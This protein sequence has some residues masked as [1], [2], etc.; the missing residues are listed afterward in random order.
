[1]RFSHGLKQEKMNQTAICLYPEFVSDIQKTINIGKKA[2][3][4]RV[5]VPIINQ[6]LGQI[7]NDTQQNTF[8]RSDLL[9]D[10]AS[11]R[12]N[13]I[14]KV[15]EFNDC[16][17]CDET[18]MKRSIQNLKLEIDWAKH[19]NS[20]NAIVLMSLKNDECANLARQFLSK[21][22][23]Y[24]LVLAEMPMVDKS[25]F[26]QKYTS[27]GEKINLS[28]AST[29]IWHRWNCFRFTLDFN[30]QFKVMFDWFRFIVLSMTHLIISII[31]F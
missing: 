16:D 7:Q 23:K 8:T 3:Y 2:T 5:V 18:I 6:P 24:G 31:Q 15:S 25:Y 17:S 27:T 19:Q 22:D 9:L 26:T 21:F 1:M 10:A 20:E 13:T 12:Q 29:N 4:N 28:T 14:L 30:P 11:W